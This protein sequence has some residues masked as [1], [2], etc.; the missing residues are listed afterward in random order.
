MLMSGICQYFL[1]K[2]NMSFVEKYDNAKA[3]LIFSTKTI[4]VF[5]NKVVKHLNSV[6]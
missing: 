1:L 3:S 4:C 5:S 6:H 2:K